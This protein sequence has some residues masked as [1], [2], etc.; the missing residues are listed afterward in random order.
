ML[1]SIDI[2]TEY[3]EYLKNI[4]SDNDSKLARSYDKLLN[5]LMIT[6]FKVDPNLPMDENRLMAGIEL[7]SRFAENYGYNMNDIRESLNFP[8][9]ILEMMVALSIFIEE[10]VMDNPI[11]GNRTAQWFWSMVSSLGLGGQDNKNIDLNYVNTVLNTFLDRKYSYNGKGG[12]FTLEHPDCDM[13]T[14]EIWW[15]A[16]RYLDEQIIK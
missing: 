12:L 3:Y 7:R 4:A 9:S 16:T 15:Q 10:N 14:I 13:R 6:E 2:L 1:Y 8:C 11:Y 5:Q